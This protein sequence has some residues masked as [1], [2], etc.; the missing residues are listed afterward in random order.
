MHKNANYAIIN[1]EV[2]TMLYTCTNPVTEMLLVG[3][4]SWTSRSLSV[5]ARPYS[6]LAFRLKGGGSLSCGGKVYNLE[7]G[8]VLYMP[9]GLDYSH[10]YTDTDLLL[11][12]FVTAQNDPEPEIYKLCHKEEICRGFQK[13]VEIW[14]E[15][16]PGYMGKCIGIFYKILGI[17]AENEVESSLPAHFIQAVSLLQEQY[18]QSDLRIDNLCSQAAISQTV[19]RQLFHR[20]YGKTPVEYVTEL[21]LEYARN[22]IAGGSSVETA[23][24]ES[25]FSDGKYFSRVVK[26]YFG[27][28]PRQLRNYG[29]F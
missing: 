27:C 12:H 29:T 16:P 17:L 14:E 15:K 8:D 13:A 1:C 2:K 23:A 21:R 4:F 28:T 26:R 11:F 7:P 19:F 24:L 20:H 10:Q 3:R 5:K 22:L 6:A 18:R 9:Q 25:G